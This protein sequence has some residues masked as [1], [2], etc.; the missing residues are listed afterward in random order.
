MAGDENQPLRHDRDFG[1][2]RNRYGIKDA[3]W[4]D[5]SRVRDLLQLG[6]TVDDA[7]HLVAPLRV[8]IASYSGIRAAAV[9]LYSGV[10]VETF[11]ARGS[12]VTF[13]SLGSGIVV[14]TENLGV[15]ANTAVVAPD[16]LSWTDEVPVAIVTTGTLAIAP[17]GVYM[18]VYGEAYT[19]Y[20]ESG[21][22]AQAFCSVV[23]TQFNARVT[24]Q[25]IP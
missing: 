2:L 21:K 25:E 3:D 9:G 20:L 11:A 17:A 18:G 24:V 23:N 7:S 19:F 4:S 1:L 22:I 12:Y 14:T 8:P 15:L 16:V 6:V 13:F 10:Q 5:R